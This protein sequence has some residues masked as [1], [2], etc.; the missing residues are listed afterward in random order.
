M[1]NRLIRFV[2]L[3]AFVV[4][5]CAPPAF[6]PVFA[7]GGGGGG[8]GGGGSGGMDPFASRSTGQTTPAPSYPNRSGTKATQKGKKPNNQSSIGDPA[9]AAAYRAAYDTIY[10]R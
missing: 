7:A 8:G 3:G 4:A 1:S 9:F 6:A 10:E 2:V 5:L